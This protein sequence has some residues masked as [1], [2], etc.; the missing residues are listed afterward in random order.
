VFV[1]VHAADTS[2]P[3]KTLISLLTTTKLYKLTHFILTASMNSK[4]KERWGWFV[5][6]DKS[7]STGGL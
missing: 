5:G 7:G 1:E 3:Q 4:L 2:R 6:C